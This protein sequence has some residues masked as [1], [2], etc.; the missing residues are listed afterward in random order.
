MIPHLSERGLILAPKGRDAV[1]AASMLSEARIRSAVCPSLK[2]LIAGLKH[3][4]GFAVVTEEALHAADLHPLAAWIGAQPEWSD[5]P[6]IVLTLRGGIERNPTAVRLL[7][8]LGNVTFLE[9]PFHPTTLVS[10]AQSAI[11]GR[12]RQF[13]ARARL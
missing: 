12:R 2:E 11:R 3:G 4:A 10:L 13:E 1:V 5:F 6:F 7:Q 9:R 8:T